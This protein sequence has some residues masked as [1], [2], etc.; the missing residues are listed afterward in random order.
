V[1]YDEIEI[2]LPEKECVCA[3]RRREGDGA[4]LRGATV[5]RIRQFIE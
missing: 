2:V 1:S 3:K 4:K 5:G